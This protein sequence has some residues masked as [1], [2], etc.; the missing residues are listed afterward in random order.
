MP[1]V[2]SNF[3]QASYFVDKEIVEYRYVAWPQGGA[4]YLVEVGG[5]HVPVDR[6]VH[7][8]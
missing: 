4:G 2:L 6:S 8:Q 1:R 7:A 3:V 5:E